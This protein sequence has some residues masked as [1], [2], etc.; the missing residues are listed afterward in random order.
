[1]P[2]FAR[3]GRAAFTTLLVCSPALSST[4]TRGAA[5][6]GRAFRKATRSALVHVFAAAHQSSRGRGPY[7]RYAAR[8]FTRRPSGLSWATRLRSPGRHQLDPVGR[9]GANPAS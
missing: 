4:T 3:P 6:P 2:I 9:V 7:G 5:D 1:M 8:A